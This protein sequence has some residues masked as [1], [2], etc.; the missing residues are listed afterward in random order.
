MLMAA[1]LARRRSLCGQ[2][3]QVLVVGEGVHRG[4][5][6]ALDAEGVVEDLHHGHE[7]VGRARGVGHHDVLA[8]VELVVVHPDHEGGVHIGG[9]ARRR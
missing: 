5:Q 6:P 1:A 8:R 7:A 3:E 9:R 4:H 2:V